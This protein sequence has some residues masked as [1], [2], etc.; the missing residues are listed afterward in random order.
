MAEAIETGN[1]STTQ[2]ATT[3]PDTNTQDVGRK[4]GHQTLGAT[5]EY[6]DAPR[7]EEVRIYNSQARMDT[8]LQPA[9]DIL[10]GAKRN[11]IWAEWKTLAHADE[12]K[13]SIP[14]ESGSGVSRPKPD[15]PFGL[16]T[17]GR[18][19]L[20]EMGEQRELSTDKP[21][22][23]VVETYDEVEHRQVVA[24]E[25]SPTETIPQQENPEEMEERP[26]A[27]DEEKNK[28]IRQEEDPNKARIMELAHLT[29][30]LRALE[31]KRVILTAKIQTAQAK[32]QEDSGDISAAYQLNRSEMDSDFIQKEIDI[33][34]YRMEI[35]TTSMS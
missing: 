9:G 19:P 27:E 6:D 4:F 34:I 33:T 5:Q 23:R 15:K 18:R 26:N 24:D 2:L 11:G 21:N 35:L 31:E 10:A 28:E 14:I 29:R 20:A 16:S 25:E 12:E 1:T 13:G 32:L 22:G 7:L 30:S 17:Q 8:G 3:T